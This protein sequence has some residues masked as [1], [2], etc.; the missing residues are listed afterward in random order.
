MVAE[1]NP[2]VRMKQ[3]TG[4]VSK[5]GNPLRAWSTLIGEDN[6]TSGE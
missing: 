1:R 4:E 3:T 2:A 5:A 6:E